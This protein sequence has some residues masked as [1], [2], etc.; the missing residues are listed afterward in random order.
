M[1]LNFSVFTADFTDFNFKYIQFFMILFV[2]FFQIFYWWK[3]FYCVFH[4]QKTWFPFFKL[5]ILQIFP[6][7]LKATKTKNNGLLFILIHSSTYHKFV[8]TYFGNFTN[9]TRS[10]ASMIEICFSQHVAI[11]FG[12]SKCCLVGHKMAIHRIIF[13][14]LRAA[15]LRRKSQWSALRPLWTW[16]SIGRHFNFK[17]HEDA[18]IRTTVVC[19]WPH[20]TDAISLILI[21]ASFAYANTTAL[22]GLGDI[23]IILL[24]RI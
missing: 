24:S 13:L 17:I 15:L 21:C 9:S 6:K 19:T 5:F 10:P 4:S 22:I 14:A 2:F 23:V 11:I 7:L 18:F 16:F 12:C 3:R 1:F 20:I 8:F